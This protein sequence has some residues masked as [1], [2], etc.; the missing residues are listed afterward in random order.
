MTEPATSRHIHAVPMVLG[1]V[2][3]PSACPASRRGE[4]RCNSRSRGHNIRP[5]SRK[6]RMRS[7]CSRNSHTNSS[8]LRAGPRKPR[9]LKAQGR[10]A[11]LIPS[12]LR[13][14]RGSP[15][16]LWIGSKPSR[17]A[18]LCAELQDAASHF[19]RRGVACPA[20]ASDVR[21]DVATYCNGAQG[22]RRRLSQ[23]G[24]GDDEA[25][26]PPRLHRDN[27]KWGGR[28]KRLRLAP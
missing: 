16:Y 26:T 7:Q 23:V 24:Q 11:A 9:S 4:H 17:P 8:M 3:L 25:A 28:G 18:S 27:P 13:R 20:Q 12:A 2:P 19:Q 14:I 21:G 6:L 15:F 22:R 1:H 5:E 10:R